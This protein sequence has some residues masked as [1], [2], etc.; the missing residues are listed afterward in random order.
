LGPFRDLPVAGGGRHPPW[1]T[2]GL[3]YRTGY[4]NGFNDGHEVASQVPTVRLPGLPINGPHT[5]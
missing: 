2:T 5:L 1:K 3:D 4:F